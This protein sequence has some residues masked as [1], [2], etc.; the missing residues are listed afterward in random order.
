MIFAV[1]FKSAKIL[2]RRL[3]ELFLFLFWIVYRLFFVAPFTHGGGGK[4]WCVHLS[5]K[6]T[7]RKEINFKNASE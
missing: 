3:N 2:V 6:H 1:S 7:E 5:K 4:M